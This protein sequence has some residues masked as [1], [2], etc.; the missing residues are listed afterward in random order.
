MPINGK[1]P[2][3]GPGLGEGG[4]VLLR[5]HAKSEGLLLIMD[6]MTFIAWP[7]DMLASHYPLYC[8]TKATISLAWLKHIQCPIGSIIPC[9]L[10]PYML[11]RCFIYLFIL[12]FCFLLIL[13]VVLG[14]KTGWQGL[15][16]SVWCFWRCLLQ[17]AHCGPLH[18]PHCQPSQPT[19]SSIFLDTLHRPLASYSICTSCLPLTVWQSWNSPMC[20]SPNRLLVLVIK[21][22]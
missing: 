13:I 21:K 4:G 9:T 15:T 17:H 1:F 8:A 11:P 5:K 3:V 7:V 18:P 16:V 14:G 20:Q 12:F 6:I 2:H 10:L 22:K 19:S